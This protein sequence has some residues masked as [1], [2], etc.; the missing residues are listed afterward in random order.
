MTD[1]ELIKRIY[2]GTTLEIE[3]FL[4]YP[5]S[6]EVLENLYDHLWKAMNQMSDEKIEMYKASY[7]KEKETENRYDFG[8]Y[9]IPQI[10]QQIAVSIS[11]RFTINGICDP[12]YICNSIALI[13]GNGDG[14]G[15]F[16][17]K[18]C[19][20][21]SAEQAYKAAKDLQNSYGCNISKFEINEL[22][23]IIR[24][25][26]EMPVKDI[27]QGLIEYIN[28]CNEKSLHCDVWRRDHLKCC[29]REA[30]NTL[31][32]LKDYPDKSKIFYCED[33]SAAHEKNGIFTVSESDHIKIEECSIEDPEPDI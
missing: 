27:R 23:D 21:L 19:F 8:R 25:N 16:Y 24:N 30:K 2:E 7:E 17:G 10:L 13:T 11:K 29:I 26:G 15:Y 33:I 3:E 14:Q 28:K 22:A 9:D 12:V 32:E 20:P 5:I 6:V 31:D 18:D 4:G 1:E